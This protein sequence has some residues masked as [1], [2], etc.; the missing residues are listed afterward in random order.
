VVRIDRPLDQWRLA[1]PH[2]VMLDALEPA[3]AGAFERAIETLR[4]AGAV[5]TDIDLPVLAE[6][7]ALQRG[8]GIP[9]A[10]S[11]AWHRDALIQREAQYDPRVALRIRRGQTVHDLAGL[12]VERRDWIARV[13]TALAGFDALLSPTVPI[14][15]PRTAPLAASDDAFF[16]ANAQ[17]LRNPSLIN[18]LDGCALSLPCHREGD[19]PVGLM[20]WSTALA[21]DRVLNISLAIEAALAPGR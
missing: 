1:V 16:A 15:A 9:A 12:L 13:E 20:V 8:G 14:V 6:A 19:W 7:A 21:D 3:V 11:W 18:L 2:T 17:L 10:E 4:A 5:I